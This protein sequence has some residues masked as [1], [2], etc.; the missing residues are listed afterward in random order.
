MIV[1]SNAEPPPLAPRRRAPVEQRHGGAWK[2]A[3]ADF[4]TAMM[5]LFMVL[6]MM[7][8]S[9]KVRKSVQGYFRDPLGY[10]RQAGTGMATSGESLALNQRTVRDLQRSGE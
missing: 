1:P 3:Y 9:D 7:N 2:V 4:V 8:S 6:W 5:A 10:K